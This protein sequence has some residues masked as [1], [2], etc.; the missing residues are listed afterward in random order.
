MKIHAPYLLIIPTIII[1]IFSQCRKP[2]K[3]SE[4][5]QI[6]F[7]DVPVKDTLDDLGNHVRRATLIFT[8][9]DGNGD[10]GL[11]DYDTLSPFNSGSKYYNNL[12]IDVYKRVQNQQVAIPLKNPSYFRTKYIE[13]QGINKVLQCTLKVDLDFILPIDFDS[14]EFV[15][16]MYDRALHQSNIESSGYRKLTP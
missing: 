8:L 6:K 14:C 13:P 16:Y 15:F 4:I 11:Q 3:V 7:V 10:I 1:L 9:I 5:P 12:Y 2:E